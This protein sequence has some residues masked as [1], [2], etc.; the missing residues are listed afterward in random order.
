MPESVDNEVLPGGSDMS[1]FLPSK[2][3]FKMA[4]LNIN[5]LVKHVDELRAVLAEFSFHILVIKILCETKLDESIKSSELDMPG[6]DFIRR[7][8]NHDMVEG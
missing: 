2:R 1:N 6:Y 5:S 4:C 8:R 7:D 3:G